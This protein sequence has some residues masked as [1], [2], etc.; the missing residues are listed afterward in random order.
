MNLKLFDFRVDNRLICVIHCRESRVILLER[1][2]MTI[3][4]YIFCYHVPK[5]FTPVVLRTLFLGNHKPI[6]TFAYYFLN[7]KA[8]FILHDPHGS[9]AQ[10]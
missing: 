7:K 6:F 1:F 9:D 2:E 10:K 8:T 3:Y 4:V 5:Y